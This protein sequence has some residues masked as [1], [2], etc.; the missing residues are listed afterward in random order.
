MIFGLSRRIQVYAYPGPV[1]MRK[2]FNTLAALVKQCGRE[3]LHGDAFLFVSS[4][5]ASVF[6]RAITA[7]NSTKGRPGSG[8]CNN[9][10]VPVFWILDSD[11]LTG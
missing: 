8:L 11:I 3:I 9:K 5:N 2:S 7:G 1:D 4:V 6:S 10:V